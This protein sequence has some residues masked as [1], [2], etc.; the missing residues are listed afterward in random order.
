MLDGSS[1]TAVID[2]VDGPI[3]SLSEWY[4]NV[5]CE[6]AVS[7]EELHGQGRR[8]VATLKV[9]HAH[10]HTHTHKYT[11]TQCTHTYTHRY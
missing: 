7:D 11:N 3:P 6:G 8:K 1:T 10:M 5:T 9:T 2:V 4:N